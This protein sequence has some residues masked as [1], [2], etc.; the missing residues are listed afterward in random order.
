MFAWRRRLSQPLGRHRGSCGDDQGDAHARQHRRQRWPVAERGD[1]QAHGGVDRPPSAGHLRGSCAA[2]GPRT[3]GFAR[4]ARRCPRPLRASAQ[5]VGRE[6]P[7]VPHGQSAAL[8]RC[9]LRRRASIRTGSSTGDRRPASSSAGSSS[10]LQLD[11]TRRDIGRVS[12]RAIAAMGNAGQPAQ[13]ISRDPSVD[14]QGPVA[15]RLE[16]IIHHQ[17]SERTV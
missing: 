13:V 10:S 2:V 4:A 17:R 1:A 11:S 14:A 6:H 7:D 5:D 9:W 8:G 3:C 15:Q 12:T 16:R